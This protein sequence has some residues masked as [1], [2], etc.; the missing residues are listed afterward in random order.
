MSLKCNYSTE[1]NTN[2][3]E[4][5]LPHL[6]YLWSKNDLVNIRTHL[7]DQE[8][9]YYKN[10]FQEALVE[11]SS[12]C[13]VANAFTQF[14][15]Q[16]CD[17]AC[18]VVPSSGRR[19]NT[20]PWY[21][22]ECRTKRSAAIEAGARVISADDQN[23][24]LDKCRE[25]RGCIQRKKRA[26]HKAYVEQIQDTLKCN[27]SNIWK[28]LNKVNAHP[29]YINMPDK[30]A[31]LEYFITLA[32]PPDADYFN[33]EYEA[34]ATEFLTKYDNGELDLPFSNDIELNVLNDNFTTDEKESVIDNLK[35]HKSPGLDN[36]PAEFIKF[37]KSEL[38]TDLTEALNYI[39]ERRDFPDSWA[40]GLRCV[41]H[42][43]GKK[44]RTENYRGITILSVF[45][46][47]FEMAVHNRLA[48]VSEA[49]GKVDEFNG[50]FLKGC[51][52][53]DNM[54]ILNGL[55]HRQ[56]LIGK[57][58]YVCYIDFSKAFDVVNRHVL[59][60]K[61]MKSGWHGRIIDTMRSLYK[62]KTTLE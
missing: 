4:A 57:P 23:Q 47:I 22:Q 50:G 27:K 21:D 61:L 48:F 53:S 37:C 19:K 33:Y 2:Y 28:V 3:S 59:F 10:K 15:T 32:T 36:I 26:H 13:D 43:A 34:Q 58:L 30:D 49:F 54:F 40:E 11:Q 1:A 51:R 39:I 14:V 55:I 41:I 8:S 16:A 60:Y 24:L 45:A 35:N 20:I 44:S 12:S 46:K 7:S 38:L 56:L 29:N 25:Y 42:K 6:K 62:K 9:I 18:R 31:L 5:W 17:R 52:T